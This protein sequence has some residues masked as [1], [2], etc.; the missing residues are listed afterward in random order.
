MKRHDEAV[1]GS[2]LQ[3]GNLQDRA[4]VIAAH[5]RVTRRGSPATGAPL[6]AEP[7]DLAALWAV[8]DGVELGDGTRVLGRGEIEAATAWFVGERAL[9]W[10]PDLW[11]IGERDDLVIVRDLDASGTRAGG[12]V[13]EAP[14]DGLSALAR[15]AMN[16]IGYLEA[17]L[18]IVNRVDLAPEQA[19]RVA[20][21]KRDAEG[22]SRALARGFYPGADR[23]E[24]QAALA[25][26]ALRAGAGDREGAM[27]AFATAV[28]ARVRS[29]PRG[30]EASE[31]AAAWRACAVAAEKAGAKEIAAAC[32]EAQMSGKSGG[33][34]PM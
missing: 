23:E 4:R 6:A 31:G 16:A 33:I 28:A 17:R 5:G 1:N 12:G 26:G 9:E 21:A 18:G 10:G 7:A 20:A 2:D 19:A 25:L 22:L 29:V 14:L 32:R 34:G 27:E 30:A 8:V 24:W 15:V 3:T 11:V 13:L